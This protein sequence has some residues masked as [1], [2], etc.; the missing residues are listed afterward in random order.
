M[1]VKQAFKKRVIEFPEG[2]KPIYR[3]VFGGDGGKDETEFS[4]H[5]ISTAEDELDCF[6]K[7]F[8]RDNGFKRNSV[9]C[10]VCV[11]DEAA[12]A[13]GDR[14]FDGEWRG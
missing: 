1:T 13:L 2:Y 11:G 6:F 10:I 3:V 4:A 14:Y 5:S 12:Y 9:I 7:D 8:C